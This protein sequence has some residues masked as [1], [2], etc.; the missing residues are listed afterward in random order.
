[1]GETDPFSKA[2][3]RV[4]KILEVKDHPQA[5]KLYLMHVDLGKLG[6]RVIV[7]GMK[8]FYTKEEIKGK[9]IVIVTN[10]K[11]AKIR[12]ITSKGMLLAAEDDTGIVSLLNPGKSTPGSE[13]SIDG[14]SRDP[15]TILEFEDFEKIN[16]TIG[17]G[18]KA[19]YNGKV[20]KSEKGVVISDKPVKK[21]A[22]IK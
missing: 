1:M 21:G 17:E 11:P 13:I 5:D 3:L 16:M 4:A 10:L 15:A 6:K 22:K 7:A 19:E 9:N 2:D 20:L 18:L 8:Q 12:G 14:I